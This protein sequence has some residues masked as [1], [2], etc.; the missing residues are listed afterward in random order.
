MSNQTLP[1]TFEDRDDLVKS[2][3]MVRGK[4]DSEDLYEREMMVKVGRMDSSQG[5]GW[6]PQKGGDKNLVRVTKH[7]E[8][9]SVVEVWGTTGSSTVACVQRGDDF[10]YKKAGIPMLSMRT[11]SV[12]GEIMGRGTAESCAGLNH[13]TTILTNL[14]LTGM[15]RSMMNILL[16]NGLSGVDINKLT[17]Q[18][19]GVVAT[20]GSTK[21]NET[22]QMIQYPNV[23]S[24]AWRMIDYFKYLLQLTGGAADL[25]SGVGSSQ[26]PD[27][28]RGVGYLVEQN[29][30]RFNLKVHT[31][32]ESIGH[33]GQIML[34]VNAEY[35]REDMVVDILGQNGN[36]DFIAV[37][38][39]I[40][41]DDYVCSVDTR[42]VAANP[43]V[44]AQMMLHAYQLG[45][46]TNPNFDK[47]AGLMEVFRALGVPHPGTLMANRGDL[48]QIE[49]D[50]F[51]SSGMFPPALPTQPHKAHMQIH[52]ELFQQMRQMSPQAQANFE[53][54]MMRE[55]AAMGGMLGMQGGSMVAPPPGMGVPE[56]PGPQPGGGMPQGQPGRPPM[57]GAQA[58]PQPGG[59]QGGINVHSPAGPRTGQGIGVSP[60][61]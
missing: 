36:R 61:G 2:L 9:G 1:W 37:D 35:M 33:L 32:H 31:A 42:P 26:T 39:L 60:R 19:F 24:D 53:F 22:L 45:A 7:W 4:I 34:H 41:A 47:D 50:L 38:P 12:P 59:P 10:P 15:S 21:L 23:T 43:S 20:D 25:T 8:H 16:V 51:L 29:A 57:Q 49:N 52:A 54:H 13:L 56:G 58:P 11:R 3:D 44:R 14:M 5:E 46:Q 17:A 48:A 40:F 30:A 55:H 18:P 28:A 27:T 6:S